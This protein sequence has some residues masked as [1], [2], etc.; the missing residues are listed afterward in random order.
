MPRLI[1]PVTA[2]CANIL[3]LVLVIVIEHSYT[4]CTFVPHVSRQFNF[5]HTAASNSGL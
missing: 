1:P 3:V 2:Q 4:G 5:P